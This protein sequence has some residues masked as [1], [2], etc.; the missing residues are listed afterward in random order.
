[1]PQRLD[2]EAIRDAVLV[3][4][5]ELRSTMGGPG[6]RDFKEV[7]RSG[8]YTYEPAEGFDAS[9][10]RRTI[11]RTWNRG[12]RSG[13][14]DA[15]D[16]PDPSVIT[17]RRAVTT[18]P[19]QALALLNDAFPLKMAA[20]FADRAGFQSRRAL[21]RVALGAAGLR[22]VDQRGAAHARPRLT[23]AT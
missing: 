2:A 20:R 23:A 1:M 9:F 16:C 15:F 7:F 12:G 10:N 17:P 4:A 11:Y 21:Q 8:T 18:T 22:Q 6:F 19:L 14:L 5:G 3:A 13:L